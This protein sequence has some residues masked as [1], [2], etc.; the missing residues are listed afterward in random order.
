MNVSY[1]YMEQNLQML[2]DGY[3][4]YSYLNLTKK[5]RVAEY[6]GKWRTEI[7]PEIK[8]YQ[9][10]PDEVAFDLIETGRKL[11]EEKSNKK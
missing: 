10:I 1:D 5:L 9:I 4:A 8:K 3:N 2:G 7:P 11:N 6:L